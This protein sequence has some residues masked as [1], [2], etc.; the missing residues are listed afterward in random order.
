MSANQILPK[1][2]FGILQ[3]IP[4]PT[5]VW[6]DI[7]MD[8]VVSLPAYQ[9]NIVILVVIDRFSKAAHFGSLLTQFSACKTAEL[10]MNI[11]CKLYGYARA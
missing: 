6:E 1:T 8:F 11:I 3:P 2:P 4:P 5:A 10:F 9:E 7:S